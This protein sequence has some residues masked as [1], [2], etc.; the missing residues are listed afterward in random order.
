MN[1]DYNGHG[2]SYLIDGDGQRKLIERTRER[3]ED[4][5][6]ADPPTLN[7]VIPQEQPA[8][9]GFFSPENPAE[10]TTTE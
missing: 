3:G 6:L 1:D 5:A 10:P 2:G 8:Q 7:E 4:P 9:A